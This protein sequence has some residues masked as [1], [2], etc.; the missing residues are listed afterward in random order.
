[1][2]MHHDFALADTPVV[3]PGGDLPAE[4]VDMPRSRS[5]K[6][7]DTPPKQGDAC[8]RIRKGRRLQ[9]GLKTLMLAVTV[10]AIFCSWMAVER[11]HYRQQDRAVKQ[12]EECGAVVRRLSGKSAWVKM[13]VGEEYYYHPTVVMFVGPKLASLRDD[14]LKSLEGMTSLECIVA[15]G[16][17]ITDDGLKYL[18][19]LDR[20]TGLTIHDTAITDD[21]LKYL[22]GLDRLTHLGI[23][24]TGVT[25]A[26][27]ANLKGCRSLESLY[28]SGNEVTGVGLAHLRQLKNLWELRLNRTALDDVGMTH[29]ARLTS[30]RVLDISSTGVTDAGV[31]HLKHLPQ[32]SE[33]SLT[34]TSI[35]NEALL[36]LKELR[37]L[38]SLR[39]EETLIDDRGLVHLKALPRL[40]SL[41]IGPNITDAALEHLE[42]LKT[43]KHL[44]IHS[45][46]FTPEAEATLKRFLPECVIYL[47]PTELEFG[48]FQPEPP[49]ALEGESPELPS[50]PGPE[51]D[52][53]EDQ[54]DGLR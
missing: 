47:L 2:W 45:D 37:N 7:D 17:A 10:C 30:L 33:L 8:N 46:D 1:M 32:L 4:D 53:V 50:G 42:S 12:V 28:L 22:R 9:F 35:T 19:G 54:S 15:S 13:L 31:R 40:E 21:G 3:K 20:L 38:Q 48:P 24:D 43:L 11:R 39:L 5:A 18:R 49:P 26:G 41:S 27:L 6:H 14:D 34:G 23:R 29:V 16:P 36:H 25:D 44:G 51:N 52:A